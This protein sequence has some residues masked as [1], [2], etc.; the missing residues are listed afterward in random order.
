[1]SIA[2]PGPD[3]T[4]TS[5][6][7]RSASWTR[8][9]RCRWE[10][11]AA[12]YPDVVEACQILLRHAAASQEAVGPGLAAAAAGALLAYPAPPCRSGWDEVVAELHGRLGRALLA[13]PHAV[14]L[15]GGPTVARILEHLPYHRRI[16][17]ADRDLIANRLRLGLCG[18]YAELERMIDPPA[19]LP[20]LVQSTAT[21]GPFD[22][23][24]EW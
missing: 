11:F 17:M 5:L 24:R 23:R 6:P 10:A 20:L 4:G 21:D 19:L 9:N 15:L 22:F 18:I 13:A 2:A 8:S 16:K 3:L 14:H 12:I 7:P 1:M